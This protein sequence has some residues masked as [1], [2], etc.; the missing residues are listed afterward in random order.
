MGPD[1]GPDQENMGSVPVVML[2]PSQ[3]TPM[4]QATF[5]CVECA[6]GPFYE[7]EMFRVD[8]L[9]RERHLCE[10]CAPRFMCRRCQTIEINYNM[11]TWKLCD[12]CATTPRVLLAWVRQL[13]GGK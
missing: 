8:D 5:S 13:W 12:D 1:V 11:R 4:P 7:E 10:T 6:E 2:H 9:G 3:R